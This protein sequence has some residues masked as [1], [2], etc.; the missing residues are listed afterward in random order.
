[1]VL[2]HVPTTI[3]YNGRDYEGGLLQEVPEELARLIDEYVEKNKKQIERLEELSYT[4]VSADQ[5]T[6]LEGKYVEEEI[7]QP[8]FEIDTVDEG[9]IKEPIKRQRK[10]QP[11]A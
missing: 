1:M 2:K 7:I 3:F 11:E 8:Q 10:P 9:E 4:A 6:A 5:T